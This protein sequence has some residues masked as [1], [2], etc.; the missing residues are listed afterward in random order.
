MLQVID[1]R[2]GEQNLPAAEVHSTSYYRVVIK[3]CAI[4]SVVLTNAM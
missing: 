3:R 4:I 1:R 2:C